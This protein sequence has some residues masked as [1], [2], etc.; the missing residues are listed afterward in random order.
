M[1]GF[2]DNELVLQDRYDVIVISPSGA[3][4]TI[5]QHEFWKSN[6]ASLIVIHNKFVSAMHGF[7]DNEILLPTGYDVNASTTPEGAART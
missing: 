7:R 6:H 3:L 4:Q 1:Y 2:W 5:F